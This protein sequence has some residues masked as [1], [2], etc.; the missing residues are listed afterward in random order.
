MDRRDVL[1]ATCCWNTPHPGVAGVVAVFGGRLSR[2]V[3]SMRLFRYPR[4]V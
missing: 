3:R 1:L 4:E 2:T